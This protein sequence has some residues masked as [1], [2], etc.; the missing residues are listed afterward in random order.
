LKDQE[1]YET[2]TTGTLKGFRKNLILLKKIFYVPVYGYAKGK[3]L[4]DVPRNTL[5]LEKICTG[6]KKA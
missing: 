5:T 3:T 2:L 6:I 1:T 4:Y